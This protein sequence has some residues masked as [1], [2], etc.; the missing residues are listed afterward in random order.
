M[1]LFTY[2][3]MKCLYKGISL[4]KEVI[5]EWSHKDTPEKVFVGLHEGDYEDV[6]AIT[7][8]MRVWKT[9]DQAEEDVNE[10]LNG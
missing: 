3:I 7:R 9:K 8:Q 6:M 1:T 10:D 4:A 2:F 5:E